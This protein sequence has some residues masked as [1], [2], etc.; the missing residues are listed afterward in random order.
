MAVQYEV[1]CP[2]VWALNSKWMTCRPM[3]RKSIWKT[4]YLLTM[5]RGIPLIGGKLGFVKLVNSNY[6]VFKL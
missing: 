5:H 2:G 3:F 1:T 6:R 4:D